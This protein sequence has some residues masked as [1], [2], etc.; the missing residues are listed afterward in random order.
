MSLSARR[1]PLLEIRLFD[2]GEGDPV[3]TSR[4]YGWYDALLQSGLYGRSDFDASGRPKLEL[5]PGI[6]LACR[7]QL[8]LQDTRLNHYSTSGG[9]WEERRPGVGAPR[10]YR[11]IQLDT[12]AGVQWSATSTWDHP[13][14][15]DCALELLLPDSPPDW[16]ATTYPPYVQVELGGGAYAVRYDT[17][18]GFLLRKVAGSWQRVMSLPRPARGDG[19]GRDRETTLLYLRFLRGMLGISADGGASYAWY[20]DPTGAAV[21]IPAGRLAVRGQGGACLFGLHKLGYSEGVYTS[22]ERNTLSSRSAPTQSFVGRYAAPGATSLVLTDV[23]TP[24]SAVA[25]YTATL[26]PEDRAALSFTFQRSPVLYATEFIYAPAVTAG[27]ET[28]TTPWPKAHSIRVSEPEQLHAGHAEWTIEIPP[29]EEPNW[30]SLRRR[31]VQIRMG[32][33]EDGVEHWWTLFTGYI[34]SIRPQWNDYGACTA[35]IRADSATARFKRS[36]WSPLEQFA[37]GGRTLNAAA[38]LILASEGLNSSF[39]SWDGLGD[40][41]TLPAGLPEDPCEL[42]RPQEWKWET[43]TRLMGYANLE[44]YADRDGHY[45]SVRRDYYGAVTAE[46]HVTDPSEI[47]ELPQSL[48][49]QIDFNQAYTAVLVTGVLP[50][51]EAGAGYAVDAPAETDTSSDRFCHWRELVIEQLPGTVS[52]GMLLARTQALAWEHFGRRETP[53]ISVELNPDVQR[54]DRIS[55]YGAERAGIPDGTEYVV[56][57]LEHAI[58]ADP[59]SGEVTMTTTAGLRL[60]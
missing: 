54:R 36:C 27:A 58:Q 31:K 13:S 3:I 52:P 43:L 17:E 37:L 46:L 26:T 53:S 39:Q 30:Q 22:P 50:W 11:I 41:F 49:S 4:A 38:D 40:L 29:G 16:D 5:L 45:R 10:T 47:S 9:T 25:C 35:T 19:Y 12:T 34:D 21:T 14:D 1:T 7:A 48:A 23:S 20:A 28:Y 55:I 57:S 2:A 56:L 42:C 33:T 24:L 60:K 6:G 15:P 8:Q 51:G 59:E 18:G 32:Y 44:P